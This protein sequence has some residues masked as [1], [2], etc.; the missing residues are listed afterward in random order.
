MQII[1]L[2]GKPQPKQRPR[3]AN[4]IFY[5][6][7]SAWEKSIKKQLKGIKSRLD[8]YFDSALRIDITF[9]M[10]RP[11]CHFRTGKFSHLLK[12]SSPRIWHCKRPDRDNLDKAVLDVMT[13]VGILSDDCIVCDG[14]IQKRWANEGSALITI[15]ELEE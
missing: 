1:Q 11:K 10:P 13:E 8:L 5:S 6:P 15:M 7:K 4:G 3:S 9:Y 14:K 2:K 12:D